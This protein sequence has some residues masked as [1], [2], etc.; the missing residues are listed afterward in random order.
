MSP[1]PEHYSGNFAEH[2]A[3]LE[4]CA[5][6]WPARAHLFEELLRGALELAAAPSGIQRREED[7]DMRPSEV[8][9]YVRPHPD[10]LRKHVEVVHGCSSCIPA[11]RGK[12]YREGGWRVIPRGLAF[13]LRCAKCGRSSDAVDGPAHASNG[14]ANGRAGA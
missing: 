3:L 1:I 4:R 6:R 2:V 8:G 14:H 13:G 9:W 10:P 11:F 7:Y 12:R 5:S